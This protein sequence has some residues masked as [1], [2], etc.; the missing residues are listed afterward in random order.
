MVSPPLSMFNCG[1]ATKIN[2]K[3]RVTDEK[4][5]K[6]PQSPPDGS[7][8][9]RVGE[10]R[11]PTLAL[12]PVPGPRPAARRGPFTP[13]TGRHRTE[14]AAGT[15]SLS[16][17][18]PHGHR[19]RY[20]FTPRSARSHCAQDKPWVFE[21]LPRGPRGPCKGDGLRILSHCH[22]WS[23]FLG[24]GGRL[25]FSVTTS[26]AFSTH[27]YACSPHTARGGRPAPAPSPT[28]AGR[29]GVRQSRQ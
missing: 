3:T 17:P 26:R 21:H 16:R 22:F 11:R 1:N 29:S 18:R 10:A 6:V 19:N 4:H 7:K 8:C 12:Y 9:G 20:L 24:A 2:H 25:S 28:L 13:R 23:P 5:E 14:S 27:A 15:P